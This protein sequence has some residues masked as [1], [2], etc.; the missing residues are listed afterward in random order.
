MSDGEESGPLPHAYQPQVAEG[1]ESDP[2]A[3]RPLT[4]RRQLR[5]EVARLKPMAELGRMAATVT[6]EIR[7]PLAGISANAELLRES[8]SDPADVELVDT[9]LGEVSRLGNL[10]TDLLY[11]CRERPAE[12][13][14]MDLAWIARTACDLSRP[15][16]DGMG[17]TLAWGG[18]GA[19][20]GDGDL[21]RQAL[22]NVLR[23]A[24]QACSR[25]GVVRLEISEGRIAVHDSGRGVPR[26]LRETMFEPFVTGK[27]RG[28]GLGATVARRCQVRQGGD[29]VLVES[30]QGGSVFALT[31][32]VAQAKRPPGST[33][34]LLPTVA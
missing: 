24:L 28:L 4:E 9:I 2:E 25:G 33:S 10:V 11:Y 30:G 31:W 15:D 8:L 18:S 16:A 20:L 23:N 5:D 29:L 17:V 21:S 14:P 34:E 27:T 6:H 32:P 12:S 19:A 22:L 7:N 1:A 13:K 26:D 3:S